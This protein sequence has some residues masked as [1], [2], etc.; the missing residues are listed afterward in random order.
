MNPVVCSSL[1]YGLIYDRLISTMGSLI[2]HLIMPRY[3]V[4]SCLSII[5]QWRVET[6]YTVCVLLFK[7]SQGKKVCEKVLWWRQRLTRTTDTPNMWCAKNWNSW[8]T[9]HAEMRVIHP[10]LAKF[11]LLINRLWGSTIH[12][13][14]KGLSNENHMNVSTTQRHCTRFGSLVKSPRPQEHHWTCL[15]MF[16][17]NYMIL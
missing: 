15:E 7:S 17:Y 10:E 8:H 14:E 9:A 5:K 11:H 3:L 6:I 2:N 12:L 1:A 13:P 4:L 16:W